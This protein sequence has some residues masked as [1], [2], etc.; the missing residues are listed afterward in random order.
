MGDVM[1]PIMNDDSGT[2]TGTDTNNPKTGLTR[3]NPAPET[4]A[5]GKVGLGAGNPEEGTRGGK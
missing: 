5:G 4:G 3:E 1:G 2:G